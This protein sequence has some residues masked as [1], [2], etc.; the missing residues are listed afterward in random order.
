MD[1]KMENAGLVEM[2]VKH[3]H[4][5]AL[6][7]QNVVQ[8]HVTLLVNVVQNHAQTNV[9]SLVKKDANQMLKKHAEIM[10]QIL[11]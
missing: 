9:H 8:E 7:P 6:Q 4:L 3:V 2:T 11:V 10:I 1:V 5:L